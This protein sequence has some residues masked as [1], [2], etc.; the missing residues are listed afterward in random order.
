MDSRYYRQQINKYQNDLA[1]L[2]KEIG[3]R[4]SAIAKADKDILAAQQAASRTSSAS[5]RKT[6]IQE[7]ERQQQKK[8][9]EQ[10]ELGR[11]SAKVAKIQ[12]D[13]AKAQATAQRA[14]THER[15]V[16]DREAKK[17]QRDEEQRNRDVSATLQ[18]HEHLH[19]ETRM[20]LEALQRLP[21]T[22]T[23]LVLAAN[24]L[25]ANYL[26]LD[27]EVRLIT[28]EIRASEYRDAINLT[29][30]WAV[31]PLDLLQALNEDKPTIIHFSGHGTENG[32]LVFQGENNT[33]RVV[34][35]EAIAETMY[36]SEGIQLVFLNACF[37]AAQAL[38]I[39]PYIPIAIGMSDTVND[40]SAR[41]FAAKFYSA[42]GFGH[43]I[44][45]AF[46]QARA[47]LLL[48]GLPNEESVFLIAAQDIDP[49]QVI[50]VRPPNIQRKSV[51]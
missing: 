38:A 3:Q 25:K 32:K 11:L 23:V 49:D 19:K 40:D 26:R 8:N 41:I 13:L 51:L 45:R 29:S 28:S 39:V 18:R 20:D 22:I 27:E 34:S 42:L 6:K 33:A 7:I 35:F 43:S 46:N 17:R 12:Q 47:A 24:P 44:Q 36:A 31:R 15:E 10:T 4:S 48:E 9:R 37:S 16:Q 50:L 30:R 1:R 2:Q 21:D 5:V 14:E